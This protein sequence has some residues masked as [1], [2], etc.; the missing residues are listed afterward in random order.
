MGSL[1]LSRGFQLEEQETPDNNSAQPEDVQDAAQEPDVDEMDTSATDIPNDAAGNEST[2][3][4]EDAEFEIAM[5]PM[6]DMLNARYRSE[7]VR[8]GW[9]WRREDDLISPQAKLFYEEN[10]LGM[11]ATK[12]IAAGEQIVSRLT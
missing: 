12:D 11:T 6:A 7:N 2:D 9:R 10:K 4:E 5:V 3:D 8:T 1:I